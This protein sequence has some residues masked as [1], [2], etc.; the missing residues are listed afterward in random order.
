MK[1]T[2][3]QAV[4]AVVD[5]VTPKPTLAELT[6]RL[7]TAKA[8]FAEARKITPNEPGS[9]NGLPDTYIVDA[10]IACCEK[11]IKVRDAELAFRQG[12]SE[13]DGIYDALAETLIAKAS[14]AHKLQAAV[15][16]AE[17]ALRAFCDGVDA[18][19]EKASE[20]ISALNAR[21]RA[22]D[23]P[24]AR[25]MPHDNLRTNLDLRSLLGDLDL[26]KAAE[27]LRQ[28]VP[29]R[30][31]SQGDLIQIRI[32]DIKRGDT[33]R[34]TARAVAAMPYWEDRDEWIAK[35]LSKDRAGRNEMEERGRELR[36]KSEGYR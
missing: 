23:L 16:A 13:S 33:A 30:D 9:L 14:E 28:P 21:R 2:I 6:E 18:D 3:K 27:L 22:D 36:A 7:R 35:W 32:N 20:A 24:G 25:A 19:V 12:D 34:E 1:N 8:E 5:A 26:T 15:K 31:P 10:T 29:G 17:D 11:A 4:A